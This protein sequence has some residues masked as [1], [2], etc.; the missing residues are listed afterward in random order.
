VQ[1]LERL[2]WRLDRAIDEASLRA[3]VRLRGARAPLGTTGLIDHHES[4]EYIEGCST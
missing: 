2:W 1:I 3:S 4:P